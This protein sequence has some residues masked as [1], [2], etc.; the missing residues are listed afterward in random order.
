MNDVADMLALFAVR[1]RKECTVGAHGFRLC[2]PYTMAVCARFLKNSAAARTALC[3]NA[4]LRQPGVGTTLGAAD[5]AQ[6]LAASGVK[7][8]L[9]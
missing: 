1:G 3:P 2:G 6:F 7:E 4:G 9:Q 5:H 8:G